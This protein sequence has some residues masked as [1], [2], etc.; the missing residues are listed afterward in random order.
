M[1]DKTKPSRRSRSTDPSIVNGVGEG[2][3]DVD[4][5]TEGEVERVAETLGVIVTDTEGVIEDVGEGDG[6]LLL[7]G[8]AD[9]EG[10]GFDEINGSEEGVLGILDDDVEGKIIGE[11]TDVT[12]AEGDIW[13]LWYGVNH[14][15]KGVAL[16]VI[17]EPSDGDGVADW[18]GEKDSEGVVVG[19]TLTPAIS[20]GEAEV[21]GEGKRFSGAV[22][23]EEAEVCKTRLD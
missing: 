19:E 18:L 20:N 3:T 8:F 7:D 12:N 14:D 17:I 15:D 5:V 23:H 4:V 13:E 2:V 10:R 22:M 21:V 11:V 1:W 6:V 9:L 16:R